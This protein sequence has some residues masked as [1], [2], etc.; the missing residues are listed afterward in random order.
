VSE[1][2]PVTMMGRIPARLQVSTAVLASGLAGSSIPIK[3][4]K[5]RWRS[6]SSLFRGLLLQGR[7]ATPSTR[8]PSL[9]IW[10]V[11][12]WI[13]RRL[14]ILLDRLGRKLALAALAVLATIVLPC[15][16]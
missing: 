13:C 4:R 10:S 9:A 6:I 11:A 2:S 3:P 7:K 5:T 14:Q 16:N 12:A 8:D 1:W 15:G